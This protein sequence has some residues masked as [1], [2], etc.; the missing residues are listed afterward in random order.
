[1]NRKFVLMLG[2]GVGAAVAFTA[3]GL[4][5]VTKGGGESQTQVLWQ[6]VPANEQSCISRILQQRGL[7]TQM[8]GAMHAIRPDD[9]LILPF[10]QQC[11]N[12]PVVT[13]EAVSCDLDA[14]KGPVA[15]QPNW[16]DITPSGPR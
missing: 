7:D 14:S 15:C 8:L 11:Q 2:V 12:Q 10:R 4:W 16:D 1:M 6:N 5:A 3:V 9:P 13:P